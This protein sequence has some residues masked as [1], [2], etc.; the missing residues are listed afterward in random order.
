MGSCSVIT[1][2][3][4]FEQIKNKGNINLGFIGRFSF[5]EG[6]TE[7]YLPI[8]MKLKINYIMAGSEDIQLLVNW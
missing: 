2:C 3:L 1:S 7:S 6:R 8:L 4:S 5:S